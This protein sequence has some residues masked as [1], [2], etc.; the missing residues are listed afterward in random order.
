VKGGYAVL[1]VV[2]KKAF[3]PVAFEKEKAALAVSLRQSRRSQFFQ[4][5]L[6]QVRPRFPVERHPDVVRRIVG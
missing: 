1:R 6:G 5:Y 4:A 2:E 3:D